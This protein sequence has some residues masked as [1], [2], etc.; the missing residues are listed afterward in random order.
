MSC[1]TGATSYAMNSFHPD[2]RTLRKR[3]GLTQKQLAEKLGSDQTTISLFELG[4]RDPPADTLEAWV[5]LCGGRIALYHPGEVSLSDI[6]TSQLRE[7]LG[8]VRA[9]MAAPEHLRTGVRIL[10]Q[11]GAHQDA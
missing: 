5:R 3:A 2:L 6:P 1:G 9:Y 8:I 4:K 7:V 11:V 10:L